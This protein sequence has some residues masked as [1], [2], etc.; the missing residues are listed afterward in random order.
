MIKSILFSLLFALIFS[1]C[2]NAISSHLIA[3]PTE[4]QQVRGVITIAI[5]QPDNFPIDRV[6]FAVDGALIPPTSGVTTS[7]Y[8]CEWDTGSYTN[9]P[10]TVSVDVL[11]VDGTHKTDALTVEKIP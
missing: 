11:G 4:G 6:Y 9:G 7:P 10:H 2:Q 5:N 1:G 8:Q 3:T